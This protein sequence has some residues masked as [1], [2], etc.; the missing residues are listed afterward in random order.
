M[1]NPDTLISD[2][3]NGDIREI[4]KLLTEF[5]TARDPD[6]WFL[7]NMSL[8]AET[9]LPRWRGRTL[10]GLQLA[11]TMNRLADDRCDPA[12]LAMAWLAHD[13]TMGFLPL[14]LLQNKQPLSRADK[15]LITTHV[16]SAA[17]LLHR[18]QGWD[19]AREMILCHHE[20]ADGLGYPQG[21]SDSE[22]CDG[23]RII[24]ITDGYISQTGN[25]L[26]GVMEIN[27][28]IETQFSPFWVTIFNAAVKQISIPV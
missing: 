12:Q 3:D 16:R 11:L 9:R 8:A 4:F 26:Q 1:D 7:A 25:R 5:S 24:A 6:L 17:D 13:I 14:R 27:R 19:S 10:K 23:G 22:S 21:Y 20:R 28:H 2:S 18:M 15:R